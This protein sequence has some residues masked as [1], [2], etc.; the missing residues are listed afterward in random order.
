[1]TMRFCLLYLMNSPM[2]SSLSLSNPTLD[3]GFGF[4]KANI[5]CFIFFEVVEDSVPGRLSD[6]ITLLLSLLHF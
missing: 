6:D 5:V 2:S 3:L 1:M 4:K